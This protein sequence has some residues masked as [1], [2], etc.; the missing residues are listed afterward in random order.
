MAHTVICGVSS[1][2]ASNSVFDFRDFPSTVLDRCAI[3]V[4]VPSRSKVFKAF[5]TRLDGLSVLPTAVDSAPT[6][7]EFPYAGARS[8]A[9]PA[10]E[11]TNLKECRRPPS[12]NLY[13]SAQKTRAS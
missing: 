3:R 13:I 11:Q 1:T 10:T 8:P 6:L 4:N 2:R 5:G 9:V 12:L 7:D